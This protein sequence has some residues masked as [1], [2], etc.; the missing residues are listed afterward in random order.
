MRDCS[1]HTTCHV[2][3]ASRWMACYQQSIPCLIKKN[4]NYDKGRNKN[5]IIESCMR[6]S[7]MSLQESA[8]FTHF[9]WPTCMSNE[10]KRNNPYSQKIVTIL[11]Y[12]FKMFASK[13]DHTQCNFFVYKEHTETNFIPG[14][15]NKSSGS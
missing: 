15:H 4:T 9:K 12:L 2:S 11:F 13:Y 8:H 1:P 6:V 10:V 14:I 3:H 7:S 5:L